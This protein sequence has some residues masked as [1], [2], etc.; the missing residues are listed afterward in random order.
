MIY[1]EELRVWEYVHSSLKMSLMREPYT[2]S[3]FAI[4]PPLSPYLPILNS[5]GLKRLQVHRCKKNIWKNL[6]KN[7]KETSPNEN[8][9]IL[10]WLP[11]C[12]FFLDQIP[13]KIW[14]HQTVTSFFLQCARDFFYNCK[15]VFRTHS[16]QPRR[17]IKKTNFAQS[18]F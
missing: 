17:Q 5:F 13:R 8:K 11:D 1:L 7:E 6:T 10:W 4:P 3:P 15:L 9:V 14:N 18:N 2:I 12:N 16:H